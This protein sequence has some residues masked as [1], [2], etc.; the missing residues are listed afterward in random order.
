MEHRRD[1]AARL[2]LLVKPD[3]V[4]HLQ[5]GRVIGAG[6][7][8]LLE[9]I[10]VP[11]RL[12]EGDRNTLLGECERHAKAYRPGPD[13]NDAI[14]RMCHRSAAAAPTNARTAMGGLR[15]SA[16]HPWRRRPSRC[17]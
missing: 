16:P 1:D 13:D 6:A 7:R 5:G 11:E 14:G 2:E 4:V 8:H 10:V 9:E 15:I 12:D 3:A 17:G